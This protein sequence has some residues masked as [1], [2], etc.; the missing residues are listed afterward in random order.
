MSIRDVAHPGTPCWFDLGS[1][2]KARSKAFYGDLFGWTAEDAGPDLGSY[3]SFSLGGDRIAG[4]MQNDGQMGPD[5]WMSYLATDDI[6]KLAEATVA[7]GGTV[8]A[9]PMAVAELGHMMILADPAGAVIGAWQP[10]EHQGFARYGEPGAPG[11]FELWTRDWEGSMAFYRE[12]FGS[13]ITVVGDSPDFRYAIIMEGDTQW[14][15]I[16]DASAFLP[17]GV[18]AHWSVYLQVDDEDATIAKAQELGGTVV[19][20][21][22]DTPYG[23]LA[24]M[25]DTTGATFKLVQPPTA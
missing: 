16:M 22:E 5:G 12:V 20:A 18:P 9:P 21:A 15:G 19:Q 25:T 17:E 24:T 6:E 8:F 23:R 10:G 11:W 4:C 7:N 13:E 3:T 2:D 1:S 14:A